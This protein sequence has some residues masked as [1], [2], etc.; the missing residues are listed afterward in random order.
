MGRRPGPMPAAKRAHRPMRGTISVV[1]RA[2]VIELAS[3][4]IART[5]TASDV[6]ALERKGVLSRH[7]PLRNLVT[8]RNA[9]TGR[10]ALA[11]PPADSTERLSFLGGARAR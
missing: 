2:L 1:D 4:S 10:L 7:Y 8:S 3:T 9:M 11:A 5:A 6:V